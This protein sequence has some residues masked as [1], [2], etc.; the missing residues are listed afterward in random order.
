MG[1]AAGFHSGK[2]LVGG[3]P[4]PDLGGGQSHQLECDPGLVD[5]VAAAVV[6]LRT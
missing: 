6:A 2:T 4:G 3:G 5:Q 1:R